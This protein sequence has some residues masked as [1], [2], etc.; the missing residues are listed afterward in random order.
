VGA[1]P[2]RAGGATG[3][4]NGIVAGGASGVVAGVG[5]VPGTLVL[6]LSGA[7][8]GESV[9]VSSDGAIGVC[10]SHVIATNMNSTGSVRTSRS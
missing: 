5:G 6:S 7:M 2:G 10:A 4:V 1:A 3:L 8:R 9:D